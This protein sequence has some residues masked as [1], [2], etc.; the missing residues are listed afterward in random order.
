MLYG[1]F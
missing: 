1:M